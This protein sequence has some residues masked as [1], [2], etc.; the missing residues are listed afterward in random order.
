MGAW[1]ICVGA[2]RSHKALPQ[3][4]FT[5]GLAEQMLRELAPLLAED[6][7]DVANID[8]PDLD[9]LQRALDRAVQHRNMQLFTPVGQ[10]RD[11]ALVTLRLIVEAFLDGDTAGAGTLLDQLQPESP[12]TSAATVASCIGIAL[13]LLD[14]WLSG[15][16]H[17]APA[18]LSHHTVLPA[19]H[20][21]GKRA[22]A[23]ILGLAGNGKAFRSL[24]KL[25]VRQGGPQ[26]VAGSALAL[27]AAVHAW[28]EQACRRCTPAP[29]PR[30]PT[31]A[32]STRRVA[33]RP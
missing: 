1:R 2:V 7:I 19:G 16:A 17:D 29:A 4:E 6:G 23:D 30:S 12:D 9:T 21:T 15:H 20:W 3:I 28:A 5:P 33:A 14:D 10:T 31:A 8:V 22:A 26:V 32:A 13:G 24:D 11:I 18:R 27:A 25:L